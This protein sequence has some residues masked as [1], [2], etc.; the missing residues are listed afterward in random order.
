MD[1]SLWV[2]AFKLPVCVYVCSIEVTVEVRDLVRGQGRRDPIRKRRDNGE[3]G[4]GLNGGEG[5]KSRVQGGVWGE[6]K[7]SLKTCME[8]YYCR[9]FQ[10]YIHMKEFKW[11]HHMGGEAVFQ[12]RLLLHK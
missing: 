7:D 9:G 4:I 3:T 12:V 1:F 5:W 11:S 10:K 8:T 2:L 6:T